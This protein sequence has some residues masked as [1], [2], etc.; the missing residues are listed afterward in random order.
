MA[1]LFSWLPSSSRLTCSGSSNRLPPYELNE[2][3]WVV[4]AAVERE[5]RLPLSHLLNLLPPRSL[6]RNPTKRMGQIPLQHGPAR[7][8]RC[9]FADWYLGFLQRYNYRRYYRFY[10]LIILNRAP[11]ILQGVQDLS[12]ISFKSFVS[13]PF[14]SASLCNIFYDWGFS[15]VV[16]RS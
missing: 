12:V 1:L 15:V 10:S 13:L 8:Y 9:C 6:L 14:Y 4:M 11:H 5:S 2:L 16:V 7:D 3:I